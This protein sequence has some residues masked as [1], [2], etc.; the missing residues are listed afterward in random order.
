MTEPATATETVDAGTDAPEELAEIV[1][2]TGDDGN[3]HRG[4]RYGSGYIEYCNRWLAAERSHIAEESVA[5]E[6]RLDRN[7][8]AIEAIADGVAAERTP[9]IVD[10]AS[11]LTGEGDIKTADSRPDAKADGDGK[12]AET[13]DAATDAKPRIGSSRR[14]P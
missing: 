9:V 5:A 13:A 12:V 11:S 4:S 7:L 8:A 3:R 1:E 14:R 2:W 10:V 6:A